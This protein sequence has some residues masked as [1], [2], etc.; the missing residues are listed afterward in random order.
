MPSSFA[1]Y[2]VPVGYEFLKETI[3][4]A[5]GRTNHERELASELLAALYGAAVPPAQVAT[6]FRVLLTR[7]E[8]LHLDVP[9]GARRC[10][11]TLNARD[12]CVCV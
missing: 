9:K 1:G 4:M 6:T 7:M 11:V 12:F 2:S 3:V 10:Q 5:L 8:D